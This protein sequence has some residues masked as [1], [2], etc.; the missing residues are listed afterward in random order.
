MVSVAAVQHQFIDASSIGTIGLLRE[1]GSKGV[2]RLGDVLIVEGNGSLS[3]IG[4]VAIW[5]LDIED[6]RHQ[7]HTICIRPTA[8]SPRFTASWLASPAGREAI[9]DSA[10]SATGLYTLSISKVET[11]PIPVPPQAEQRRIVAKLE[12]LTTKSRRAK[13]AL[14]AIPALLER[15]RQSVLA[16]AFRGDLT[17]DWREKNPDV[18]PAEELLK[19]IRAERRRRWEEAELAKM[20]AKGKVPGDDRWKERYEEPAK[21][22]FTH[23]TGALPQSWTWAS[24]NDVSECLDSMRVPVNRADR[25]KR[26]G[27]YPYY[28]ANGQV[29]TIDRH[30]FDEELILVTEDETFYGRTKPIAYRVSGKCWVNNHAHVLRPAPTVPVDYLWRVLMHYPVEPWLSGTTGRAKL[31]QAALNSLP[32]P[33]APLAEMQKIVA[34]LAS[35]LGT[36]ERIRGTVAALTPAIA[37]LD[38]VVLAKAFRGELVPQ[39]PNDEPASALL[40]RIRAE[41]TSNGQ[42]TNGTRR[43]RKPA[44][45][46]SSK[47]STTGRGRKPATGAL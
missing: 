41:A 1:D 37:E 33:L 14:D 29:G 25:E 26:S 12:T 18:E 34:M 30:L 42:P 22:D 39:D 38:R 45:P 13:E 44:P 43:P 19:R 32:I 10:T 4:R 20:R 24:V 28:G 31:T 36:A 16:A 27:A 47:P 9:I 5:D 21:P 8:T 3:H 11:L 46:E 2:L 23:G 40:E 15:F 6:A 7:N 17:A 35:R